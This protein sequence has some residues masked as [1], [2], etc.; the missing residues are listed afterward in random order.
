MEKQIPACGRQA[1]PRDKYPNGGAGFGM[2]A[3]REVR[4][5]R[6]YVNRAKWTELESSE[7]EQRKSLVKEKNAP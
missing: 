7:V 4:L 2:T 1:S 6:H 5:P 3:S